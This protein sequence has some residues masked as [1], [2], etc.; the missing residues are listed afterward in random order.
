MS[1][2]LKQ[3]GYSSDPILY[4]LCQAW[5]K[6]GSKPRIW[7]ETVCKDCQQRTKVATSSSRAVAAYLKVV[8]RRKPSSAEGTRRGSTRERYY[9]PLVR[10]FG[11]SPRENFWNLSAS[12]CVFNGVFMRLG[13]DFS[14]FCHKDISCR[15]W[16]RMLDKTVSRESHVFYYF[17]VSSMFLW[18]Y[19][20][21][22]PAG[23][24]KVVL[25]LGGT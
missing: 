14:L 11:G 2:T 13:P 21:Y 23:F 9:S 18:H 4:M 24:S 5:S 6:R 1:L 3:F 12:M 10:G 19:F 20:I 17:F 16:N 25:I 15:L 7:I 22:V 8:R